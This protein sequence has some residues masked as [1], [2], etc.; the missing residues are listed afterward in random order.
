MEKSRQ[1][2]ISDLTGLITGRKKI[3]EV[4]PPQTQVFI[5]GNGMYQNDQYRFSEEEY[6]D[7]SSRLDGQSIVLSKVSPDYIHQTKET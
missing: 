5:K 1:E 2:K 4:L 6:Q 3:S 7:W